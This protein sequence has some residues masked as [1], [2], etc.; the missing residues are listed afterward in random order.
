MTIAERISTL[1]RGNINDLIDRAED[2]EKVIKQLLIDMNSQLLQ[3][4]TQ[5]AAAIADEKQLYERFQQNKAEADECQKKAEL[6]VE[7][8]D[9]DLAREALTRRTAF[10]QTAD[11]FKSQYD[12]QSRQV[13]VLKQALEQLEAKIQEA[14]TKRDL[15]IARSRG[16]RAETEI[17]TTLSGLD[18][19][20]AL[21]SFERMEQKVDEQEARA[22][23]LGEVDADSVEARLAALETGEQVERDSGR[24]SDDPS[25][26]NSV[27]SG[28]RLPGGRADTPGAGHRAG[29]TTLRVLMGAPTVTVE[30]VA[31]FPIAS[32]CAPGGEVVPGELPGGTVATGVHVGPYDTMVETYNELGQ[33]IAGVGVVPQP[34]MWEVYFTDPQLSG[35]AAAV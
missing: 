7:K 4:K 30:L 14:E 12:E 8:G 6:A 21:A 23:A 2:P 3:A 18:E 29:G 16:A 13:E 31:G 32:P 17:R 33:W 25:F 5:V 26:G 15:L 28:T 20:S 11:G 22:A 35:R 9:D 24:P 34:G 10:Q 27:V 19:G 1:V